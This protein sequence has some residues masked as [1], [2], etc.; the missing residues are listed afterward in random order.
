MP[1]AAAIVADQRAEQ[2]RKL[3]RH[4]A[5]RHQVGAENEK[6]DRQ[7]RHHLDAADHALS[8][9]QVRHGGVED[10]LCQHRRNADDEK[11]FRARDQQGD[12]EHDQQEDNH[13]PV[14]LVPAKAGTQFLAP[15]FP[16]AR[17]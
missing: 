8:D 12:G 14:P 13:R 5:T 16:L 7:Q 9:D 4:A 15:G 3:R 2:V 17:E 6:R 11:D 10:V 1:D